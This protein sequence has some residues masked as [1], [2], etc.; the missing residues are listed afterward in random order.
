MA[1]TKAIRNQAETDMMSLP[2]SPVPDRLIKLRNMNHHSLL[3]K[4]T[5]LLTQQKEHR[6]GIYLEYDVP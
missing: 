5:P 1:L 4:D 3:H 6:E 2:G